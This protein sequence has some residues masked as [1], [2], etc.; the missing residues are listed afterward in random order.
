MSITDLSASEREMVF[1]CL[2]YILESDALDNDFHTR[3]GID[4]WELADVISRWP[5]IED[6]SPEHTDYLAVNN[7]MNE[8]CHA[9]HFPE[10]V[11]RKWF[12]VPHAAICETF[13]HW[14]RTVGR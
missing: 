4:R 11:W 5:E 10:M 8:V 3:T 2:R 1:Q 13:Q 14:L 7:C 9:L 6:H 12:S